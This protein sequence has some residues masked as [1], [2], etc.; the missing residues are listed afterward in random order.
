MATILYLIVVAS[1][2]LLCFKIRKNVK[3]KF[4]VKWDKNK[5]PYCPTCDKPLARHPAKL[6]N[7]VI[8]GID[9]IKC[10]KSLILMTDDGKR[11]TLIEAK[12]LM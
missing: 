8:T 2:A 1:Y 6:E 5:E 4:G 10:N 3:P 12:K 11:I 7:A 9:C